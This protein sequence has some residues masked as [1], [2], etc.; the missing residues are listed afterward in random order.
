M[1]TFLL[2]VLGIIIGWFISRSLSKIG[3][4]EERWIGPIK[5]KVTH[6]LRWW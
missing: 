6:H 2:I 1:S 5:D 3:D 4:P